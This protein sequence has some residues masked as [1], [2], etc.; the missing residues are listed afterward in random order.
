MHST[1]LLPLLKASLICFL[2]A[3]FSSSADTTWT[4][5]SPRLAL[6]IS[7]NELIT[8]LSRPRRPFSAR[9]PRM[10]ACCRE[11]E[12]LIILQPIQTTYRRTVG[13]HWKLLPIWARLSKLSASSFGSELDSWQRPEKNGV[14]TEIQGKQVTENV[15]FVANKSFTTLTSFSTASSLLSLVAAE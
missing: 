11:T 1:F 13:S 12:R 9:T 3:G 5:K 7:S 2:D 14:Y 10:I 15:L 6:T 4:V 8:S